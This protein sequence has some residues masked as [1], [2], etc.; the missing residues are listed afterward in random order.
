MSECSSEIV[1]TGTLLGGLAESERYRV[2]ADET[3][4]TALD[5]LTDST[6]PLGLED[7][8]VAVARESNG[9]TA[10]EETVSRVA[11]ELHHVHLPKLS[12]LDVVEYDPARNRVES[13]QGPTDLRTA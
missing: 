10:D 2:L 8:A 1:D 5:V 6:T 13:V 3:R 11:S 7:L 9:D 12:D 4:R